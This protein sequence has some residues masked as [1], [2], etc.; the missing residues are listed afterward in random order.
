MF[1]LGWRAGLG[2]VW[3]GCDFGRWLEQ[4][5]SLGREQ[6]LSPLLRRKSPVGHLHL[7]ILKAVMEAG[8]RYCMNVPN[9]SDQSVRAPSF[10]LPASPEAANSRPHSP[11]HNPMVTMHS[12]G[13]SLAESADRIF[14]QSRKWQL[15]SSVPLRNDFVETGNNSQ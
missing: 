7:H 12:A 9:R 15:G 4:Q 14:T 8:R 5:L 3:D 11:L 13:L 6:A 10:H 2:P 1:S